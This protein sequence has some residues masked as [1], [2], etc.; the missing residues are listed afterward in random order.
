MIAP[1]IPPNIIPKIV[2][3]IALNTKFKLRIS[4]KINQRHHQTFKKYLSF[5]QDWTLF[6]DPRRSGKAGGNK[7][8][9]LKNLD[10]DKGECFFLACENKVWLKFKILTC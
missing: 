1:N 2:P 8:K 3:K 7:L 10:Y 6:S 9:N 4:K 5:A